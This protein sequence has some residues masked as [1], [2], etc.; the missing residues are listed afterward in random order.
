MRI[1]R[2]GVD[3]CCNSHDNA[4]YRQSDDETEYIINGGA[5]AY[6]KLIERALFD[7]RH[8]ANDAIGQ[9]AMDEALRGV[10]AL[11][12]YASNNGSGVVD[13]VVCLC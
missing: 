2:G 12:R 13:I 1:R 10:E 9:A 8:A 4:V 3:R 6:L 5:T 11:L 7:A